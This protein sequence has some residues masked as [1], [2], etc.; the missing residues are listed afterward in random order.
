MRH[1]RQITAPRRA[2]DSDT[3]LALFLD[4]VLAFLSLII[5]EKND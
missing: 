2:V 4:I 1:I 3:A 5:R